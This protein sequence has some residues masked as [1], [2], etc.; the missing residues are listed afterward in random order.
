VPYKQANGGDVIGNGKPNGTSVAERT[1]EK[2]TKSTGDASR[3]PEGILLGEAVAKGEV[4]A[5]RQALRSGIDVNA[6]GEVSGAIWRILLYC[7]LSV[8]QPDFQIK[9]Y[10]CM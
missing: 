3:R 2:Q 8:D 7:T 9:R 10:N 5:V 4:N 1:E 6:V